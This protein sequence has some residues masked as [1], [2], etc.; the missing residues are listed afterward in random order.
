MIR[1]RPPELRAMC[2]RYCS[3]WR[4]RPQV[5]REDDGR[6]FTIPTPT[7]IASSTEYESADALRRKFV[8][9]RE[10]HTISRYL[11]ALHQ[12]KL[13]GAYACGAHV[14]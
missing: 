14:C 10:W 3:F 13:N 11:A 5:H 1:V 2:R 7:P 8:A 4:N 6:Q 9:H 12:P